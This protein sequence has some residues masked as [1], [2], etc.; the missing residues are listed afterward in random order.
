VTSPTSETFSEDDAT[1]YCKDCE[2]LL[3][4]EA[5]VDWS[6]DLLIT[7]APIVCGDCGGE[8]TRE[9]RESDRE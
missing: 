2:K 1:H 8:N 7:D 5:A 3:V 6:A 4:V 9:V